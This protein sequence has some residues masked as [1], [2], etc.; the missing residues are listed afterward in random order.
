MSIR[1]QLDRDDKVGVTYR[2]SSP[3]GEEP[4][5][6]VVHY[7]RLRR[8]HLPVVFPM[9]GSPWAQLPPFPVVWSQQGYAIADVS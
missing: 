6:R 7:D 8:Y 5:L 9:E 2:I 1:Q 4:P 3:F